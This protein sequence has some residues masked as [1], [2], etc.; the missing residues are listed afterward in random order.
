MLEQSE[1]ATL[2]SVYLLAMVGILFVWWRMTSIIPWYLPKQ[3]LRIIVAVLLIVPAPVSLG[4]PEWAPALFVWLFD[5]ALTHGDNPG[6]GLNYL[7]AGLAIALLVLL[8]DL[9]LRKR[10]QQAQ[11]WESKIFEAH[12]ELNFGRRAEHEAN[13]RIAQTVPLSPESLSSADRSS[14]VATAAA[15]GVLT[16]E[17]STPEPSFTESTIP[18]FGSSEPTPPETG[19]PPTTKPSE[20]EPKPDISKRPDSTD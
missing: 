14:V 3:L 12:P 8:A 13:A 19:T 20:P 6:R 16:V 10:K 4:E 9:W 2:W 17:A 18:E 15:A 11:T 7:L 1:Y 5:V